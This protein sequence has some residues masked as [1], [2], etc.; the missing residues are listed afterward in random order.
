MPTGPRFLLVND[1]ENGLFLLE[2]AVAREFPNCSI[3]KARG[4]TEALAQLERAP[5]DAI[6]TD[7]RMPAMDGIQMVRVI[8][9]RDAQTPILMLTGS[10][11]LKAPALAAGVTSFLASGSWDDIRRWMRETLNPGSQPVSAPHP[12]P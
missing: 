1:D 8:R 7:N 12:R 6:V 3:Q 2:R 10:E 9:T 5:V 11:E 4:A